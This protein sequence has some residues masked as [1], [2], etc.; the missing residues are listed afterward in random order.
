MNCFISRNKGLF[1]LKNFLELAL[2]ILPVKRNYFIR[3]LY[4][5]KIHII[6]GQMNDIILY[7]IRVISALGY[8]AYMSD[9]ES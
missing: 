1:F 3:N 7:Y 2:K 4:I 8:A 5:R 6:R 9:S